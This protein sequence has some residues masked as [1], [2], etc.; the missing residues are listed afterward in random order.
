M[1]NENE[2]FAGLN[3]KRALVT[4]A[5]SGIGRATAIL[6]NRYGSHVTL[7][8]VNEAG[9]KHTAAQLDGNNET[10][11]FDA[12]NTA[13][14]ETLVATSAKEGLD[15]VCNIGGILD[16]G[17]TTEFDTDRF[18]RVLQINLTA[19][20]TI[21]RAAYPYLKKTSGVIV[22]TAS[23][24]AHAGVP[25]SAAYTASK[26]GVAGLTKSLA[27]EW[28]SQNVRVNA[29]C[30]G[31]VDT[32]M[33]NQTPPSEDIDWALVMRNAPKL[34]DGT[35]TPAEVAAQIIWL[36]S[37]NCKKMTGSLLT[38]DAGQLAG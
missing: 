19:T 16:W 29:I 27:V 10:C 30:P 18:A 34:P 3:G 17:L 28:A 37:D 13:S 31:H 9:L 36:A 6:L 1:S 11:V 25:Y 7:G 21:C 12:M 2:L 33:G 32:P 35:L 5:A 14:C 8:D 4:G 24:A 23:T 15:I 20:Y 22:N 38:L 26:H